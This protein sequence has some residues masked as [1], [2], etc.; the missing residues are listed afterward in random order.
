MSLLALDESVDAEGE[1]GYEY[2]K[3]LILNSSNLWKK[4]VLKK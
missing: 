4:P 1:E 2:E 3:K